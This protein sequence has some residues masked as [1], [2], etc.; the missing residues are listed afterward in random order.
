[1]RRLLGLARPY[2]M[3]LLGAVLLMMMVGAAQALMAVLIEP[4][5]DRVLNPTSAETPVKLFTLPLFGTPLYL[6]Q[7]LPSAIHNVWTMVAA[8]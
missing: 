8:A 5:F 7:L 6:N 1:M 3:A 4:V 2:G